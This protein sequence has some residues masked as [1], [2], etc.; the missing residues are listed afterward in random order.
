MDLDPLG[1]FWHRAAGTFAQVEQLVNQTAGTK[2][3]WK[4]RTGA[5]AFLSHSW[6]AIEFTS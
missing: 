1:Q 6:A 4:I 3:P 2:T 5:M